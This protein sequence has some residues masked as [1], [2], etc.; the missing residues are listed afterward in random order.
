MMVSTQPDE[1]TILRRDK[2]VEAH[3]GWEIKHALG[4]PGWWVATAG[5]GQVARYNLLGDLMDHLESVP[6]SG[7]SQ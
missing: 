3:E 2:W 4:F 5:G 1:K 6:R 7:G